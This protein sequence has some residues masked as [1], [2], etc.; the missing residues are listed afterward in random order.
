VAIGVGWSKLEFEALGW[1]FE[2]RGVRTDEI[3]D[4]LRTVWE[5]DYV[6]IETPHYHLPG[7][8]ILPKPV[9]RIPIWVAGHSEPGYRRAVARGDG[10]HGEAGSEITVDNVAARVARI[11]R[12]KPNQDFVFS[13][14]TWQWDP[15]ERPSDEIK[16]ERDIYE[17]A[18]VQHVVIALR[19]PD[20][21]SRL[22]AVEQL[23]RLFTLD[24]R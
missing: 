11:R 21:D 6:P 7:V 14:Y 2:D 13:V 23:A 22:K 17:Q 15:S 3:I 8:R 9:H 20:V 4:I 18:G 5:E 1:T 19:S 12:D 10:F 16:R 24:P